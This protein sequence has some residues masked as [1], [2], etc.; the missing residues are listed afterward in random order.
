MDD[1]DDEH[2]LLKWEDTEEDDPWL[3]EEEHAAQGS[4]TDEVRFFFP[5]L[6]FPP[7][8]GKSTVHLICW[9]LTCIGDTR[10]VDWRGT[11]LVEFVKQVVHCIGFEAVGCL[12]NG[13]RAAA[14]AWLVVGVCLKQQAVFVG[15]VGVGVLSHAFV[16]FVESQQYHNQSLFEPQ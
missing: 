6:L 16:V 2:T 7:S 13:D 12:A 3:E 10:S 5:A 15:F 1:Y 9:W 14:V 4:T 8:S 11:N